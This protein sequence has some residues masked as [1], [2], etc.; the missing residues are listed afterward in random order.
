MNRIRLPAMPARLRPFLVAALVGMVAATHAAQPPAATPGADAAR[1]WM[2]ALPSAPKP[3]LTRHGLVAQEI[4]R[5]SPRGAGQGVAV[6]AQHFYGI[7]NFIVGKYDKKTGERVG[8][9]IGLRGGP[10]VHLNGGLVQDRLLVL[11]HSNFPELPMAS[12]V[13]YFDP[14]TVQ[15]VKSHSLGVRH[16]SLTW[17]E[18]KDG[19][20]WAGFANYSERGGMPGMDNRSTLIGKF[21]DQWRLLESWLFPAQ[22]IATWGPMSCSGGS[23]GDDGLLYV[24]GHDAKE[25][26]ALRRPKLGVAFEYVTTIDVPFEGQ[27]WA[28]DRSEK[29]V[30]YG[31]TR[32]SRE[33]VVARIPELP[34][35]LLNPP[36]AT[37]R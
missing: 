21:D 5:W 23:W 33:V 3:E 8:E 18:K 11:S 16:G 13:E 37:K 2:A 12:S 17:A 1:A 4:R 24:T 20:W 6:D 15:P 30:I 32:S 34:A 7:G 22:V 28:W 14:A 19:F 10:I 36:A 25:L 27:S 35:S 26:Y 31:I 29:R 9:W